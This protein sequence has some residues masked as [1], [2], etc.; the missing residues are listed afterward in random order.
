MIWNNRKSQR[1]L[2]S[3]GKW[4]SAT[5]VCRP[6]VQNDHGTVIHFF[7]I[8]TKFGIYTFVG[9]SGQWTLIEAKIC[10]WHLNVRILVS[11][12]AP[13]RPT[14]VQMP[15]FALIETKQNVRKGARKNIIN[16]HANPRKILK[17]IGAHVRLSAK[18]HIKNINS[19]E[20]SLFL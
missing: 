12:S 2:S 20:Y 10:T 7:S 15:S 9:L 13:F 3:A 18:R 11:T 16:I 19:L 1:Q 8:S 14:T 17:I 5:V 6:S 4:T